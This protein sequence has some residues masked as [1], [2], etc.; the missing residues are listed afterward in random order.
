MVLEGLVLYW[1]IVDEVMVSRSRWDRC[2]KGVSLRRLIS[3]CWSWSGLWVKGGRTDPP[4]MEV[5]VVRRLW[6]WVVSEEEGLCWWCGVVSG[7]SWVRSI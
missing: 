3:V 5:D 4:R 7:S 1:R 6:E 2:S